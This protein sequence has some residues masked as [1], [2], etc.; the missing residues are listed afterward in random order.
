MII[1]HYSG[2]SVKNQEQR[3]PN[4][5]LGG[6]MSSS[7]IPND[8][9]QSLF[10][11][12]QVSYTYQTKAVFFRN[13]L[14]KGLLN[15]KVHSNDDFE[16]AVISVD[17]DIAYMDKINSTESLPPSITFTP[18][19]ATQAQAVMVIESLPQ[20]GDS[21]SILG[22]SFTVGA[23]EETMQGFIDRI[24]LEFANNSTYEAFQYELD[25]VIFIYKN[26]GDNTNQVQLITAGTAYADSVNFAGGSDPVD[27]LPTLPVGVFYSLWIKYNQG[28]V[29]SKT[30]DQLYDE[31]HQKELIEQKEKNNEFISYNEK[32]FLN[33]YK[34]K[35]NRIELSFK[36]DIAP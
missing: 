36:Y 28:T 23:E 19:K 9:H 6:Y 24:I 22:V 25:S 26:V 31:F 3:D 5:S 12:P 2:A 15:I 10:I 20:D 11:D 35:V 33:S 30:F 8:V 18:I 7:Q 32:L 29:N 1:L 13:A 34:D 14:D 17:Q 16:I 21:I 4:I 27:L